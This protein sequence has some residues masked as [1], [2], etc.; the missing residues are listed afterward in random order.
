MVFTLAAVFPIT[1]RVR[2]EQRAK[3]SPTAGLDAHEYRYD[4]VHTVHCDT[5]ITN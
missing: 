4:I 1:P 5:V 3:V 2:T